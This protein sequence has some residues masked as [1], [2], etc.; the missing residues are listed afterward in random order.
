MKKI[1][2]IIIVF[3]VAGFISLPSKDQETQVSNFEECLA[4][5]NPAMESYPRQ[6]RHEDKTFVED[7]GKEL[8]KYDIETSLKKELS[9]SLLQYGEK[10][11]RRKGSMDPIAFGGED[12]GSG[13][14][15]NNDKN[16]SIDKWYVKMGK[17]TETGVTTKTHSL[18]IDDTCL[19]HAIGFKNGSCVTYFGIDENGNSIYDEY[20]GPGVEIFGKL[21]SDGSIQVSDIVLGQ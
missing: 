8:K 20:K 10:T 21:L 19:I 11:V 16:K 14:L 13:Q 1:L 4:A 18:K 15:F 7:I 12:L 5:G 17:R 3:A 2:L 6:C 9:E